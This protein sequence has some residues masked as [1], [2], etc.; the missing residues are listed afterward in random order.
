[1]RSCGAGRV[2]TDQGADFD[3]T[4]H[5]QESADA[6]SQTARA[7]DVQTGFVHVSIVAVWRRLAAD[8]GERS[9]LPSVAA[10]RMLVNLRQV[11]LC[12]SG[13]FDHEPL[14]HRCHHGASQTAEPLG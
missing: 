5:V 11:S 1:M 13:L 9:D 4:G 14:S 10:C 8:R 2:A 6:P 7:N 12:L 3:L